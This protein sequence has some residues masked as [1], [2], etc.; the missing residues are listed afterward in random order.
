M[1]LTAKERD[2]K[3]RYD[4]LLNKRKEMY[5][6]AFA[7]FVKELLR[8]ESDSTP[9]PDSKR[10]LLDEMYPH[11]ETICLGDI[12]ALTSHVFVNS[13]VFNDSF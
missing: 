8:L 4:Y 11:L 13:G 2:L 6:S 1:P 7:D 12:S 9:M 3:E 10:Q 5:E